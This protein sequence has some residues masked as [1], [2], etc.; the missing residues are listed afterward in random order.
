VD[1][2]DLP[3]KYQHVAVEDFNP[4][5]PEELLE[6]E[7]LNSLFSD[8]GDDFDEDDSSQSEVTRYVEPDLP[9]EGVNL[10]E[11]LSDL[12]VNMITQALDQHEWVVARSAEFLGMRRTTLVEK[13]RKYNIAK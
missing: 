3:H 11:Y 6:R 4:E 13:M 2:Q 1:V 5:Y 8:D 10:K 9:A 12:E 7:A